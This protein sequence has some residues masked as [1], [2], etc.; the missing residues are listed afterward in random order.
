M[1][2][3]KVQKRTRRANGEGSIFQRKDGLWC[4]YITVG[5]E[6]NGGQKKKYVYGKSKADVSA[7]LTEISGRIK[8]TAYQEIENKR[9]GELMSEWLLVFKKSSVTSRTFEG[10]FRNYKL[11]IEPIVG[12][13]K[14]YE[15]DTMTIQKVVNRMLEKGYSVAVAKKI[16]FIFNQFCEYAIDSKWILVNPTNKIKIRT[17]DK[18]NYEKRNQYKAIPPEERDRFLNAL[19]KDP[20]NFI[21][22]MCYLMMFAG[23]RSGETIALEWK[24]IDFAKRI[25]KVE[26]AETQDTKFD[27]KG[28]IVKRTTIVSD[29][30]TACSVREVPMTDIVY[31]E[32]IAWKE[33]QH[34]HSI[35]VRIDL[36]NPNVYVF[37]N[38]DGSIRTYSGCRVI[39]NRFIRRNH[40]EDLNIHFHGLRHTFSNMLFELNENPKVIQQLLGHKDVKTTITV[41]NNVNSDYVKES[42]NRLNEKLNENEILR[43]QNNQNKEEQ[44]KKESNLRNLSDEDFDLM[45]EEML[46]ERKERKRKREKDFEM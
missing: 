11:H 41:Y 29:T 45:L 44:E 20:A 32:L 17:R 33:K 40:L 7:K 36:T 1:T 10:I 5:F 15:L 8:N 16:K 25:I 6:E 2:R 21:K 24:H 3:K 12:N 38:D 13:M 34:K 14:I 23:L 22:P 35:D 31:N 19:E 26:Q 42:A 37:A 46:K 27:N 39:F 18:S 28:N 30:K 4:G 9:L 43:K